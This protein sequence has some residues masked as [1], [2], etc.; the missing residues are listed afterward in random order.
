ML[1]CIRRTAIFTL[2]FSMAFA[3]LNTSSALMYRDVS[4]TLADPVKITTPI[5]VP[6]T[7][8]ASTEDTGTWPSVYELSAPAQ[9][10][11]EPVWGTDTATLT[12][13][14]SNATETG[15]ILQQIM[16]L[17][18]G[19]R[20]YLT[21]AEYSA[22]TT[23]AT[24]TVP[25]GQISQYDLI[26]VNAV[27]GK[28]SSPSNV[29]SIEGIPYP[30]KDVILS[31]DPTGVSALTLSWKDS[32]NNA[33]LHVKW[34]LDR[35]APGTWPGIFTPDKPGF[36]DLTA[37]YDVACTYVLTAVSA[38]GA[39]QPVT[40]STILLSPPKNFNVGSW[41]G[42]NSL[43]LGWTDTRSIV[44]HFELVYKQKGFSDTYSQVMTIPASKQ[45][46]QVPV[47]NGISYEFKIRSIMKQGLPS[48]YSPTAIHVPYGGEVPPVLPT[49][50][51]LKATSQRI[52][53][54]FHETSTNVSQY[55]VKR[56]DDTGGEPF[57]AGMAPGSTSVT[58][59][60]TLSDEHS[61]KPGA[62]YTYRI[63]AQNAYGESAFA[64]PV[65]IT[66]PLTDSPVQPM[67]A[68]VP[69]KKIAFQL[70]SSQ[71]VVDGAAQ[72]I[73]PGKDTMPVVA[74]SGR[75]LIPIRSMIEKLGGTIEWIAAENKV[76][77]KLN[78]KT[79]E[80]I[81]GQTQSQVNGKSVIS[82]EAP[83]IINGRTML[84]VRF[85]SENLGLTVEW[86]AATKAIT[87]QP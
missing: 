48:P 58:G 9:L 29:V 83:Q 62:T 67:S 34:H 79:V 87:V 52:T 33:G 42:S 18:E 72:T 66:L 3:L 7:P 68:T 1:T 5:I 69:I 65:S 71:M 45:E 74:A 12:W 41:P 20:S 44:D 55:L 13:K 78:G 17:D 49:D 76:L 6:L 23:S 46:V 24:I 27:Q 8:A 63:Q 59:I 21:V 84:P 28:S 39:S 61:L 64:A 38:S 60:V 47:S 14:D 35:T 11:I 30:P 43:S 25:K 54:T 77:V 26:A 10:A 19:T 37:P 57:V 73:D 15:F 53:I 32:P 16:P 2:A 36:Q 80:L 22:N 56:T 86:N 50:I 40:L 4:K 81:I 85:V 82:D 51:T 75:T 70:G 31:P